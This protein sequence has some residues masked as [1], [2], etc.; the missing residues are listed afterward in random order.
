M[1]VRTQKTVE[2]TI[3]FRVWGREKQRGATIAKGSGCRVQG[4]KKDTGNH[5]RVEV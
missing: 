4:L 5:L 3:G 2:A 1:I